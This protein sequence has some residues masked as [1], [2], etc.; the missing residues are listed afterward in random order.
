MNNKEIYLKE[1]LSQLSELNEELILQL[2]VRDQQKLTQLMRIRAELSESI[3]T[4]F[5]DLND[6]FKD[7]DLPTQELAQKVLEQDQQILLSL[8]REV[9][10]LKGRYKQLTMV[11]QGRFT[12]SNLLETPSQS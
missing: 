1:N 5:G 12:K 10:K 4:V 3:Y 8:E 6:R 9:Q 7:L 11:V 2:R